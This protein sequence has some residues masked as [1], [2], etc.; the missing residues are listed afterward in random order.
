ME[1]LWAD[2]YYDSSMNHFIS[3][4]ELFHD[5]YLMDELDESAGT[6][7]DDCLENLLSLEE[8]EEA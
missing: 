1:R 6:M 5:L 7:E 4:D 2:K 3:V 8:L